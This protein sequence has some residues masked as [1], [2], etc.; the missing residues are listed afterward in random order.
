[1][2]VRGAS[3]SDDLR[4]AARRHARRG[5]N[6]GQSRLRGAGQQPD[7]KLDAAQPSGR[8]GFDAFAQRSARDRV[9]RM[10]F[11]ALADAL[12]RAGHQPRREPHHGLAVI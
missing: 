9:D 3:G 12:T 11:A 10:E 6:A 1:M 2:L 7:L 5:A 8:K 4:V